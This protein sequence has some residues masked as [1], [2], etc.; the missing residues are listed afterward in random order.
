ML[1]N[2]NGITLIAMI[3]TIIVMLILAGISIA[4][5]AGENGVINK[6]TIAKAATRAGEIKEI[7]RLE[8]SNNKVAEFTNDEQKTRDKVIA[9]LV[10][11]GKLTPEEE[12]ELQN[13]ETPTITIGGITI[14]FSVLPESVQVWTQSGT[15]VTDGEITLTVGTKVSGYRVTGHEDLN[16]YVLGAKDGKLL[17]T[18]DTCPEKV[19]L[20]GTSG[21][22][23]ADGTYP[24][25]T[26]LN[27]VA[28]KYGDGDLADS[29]RTI[30]Y[31]DINRITGY[32][33]KTD[34]SA[35][36]E[37]WEYGNKVTYTLK[38]DGEVWYKGTKQPTEWTVSTITSF[39]YWDGTDWTP[40]EPGESTPN[41]VECTY[42]YCDVSSIDSGAKTLLFTNTGFYPG[43][44]SSYW[45][46][47][48]YIWCGACQAY[49]GL[50]CVYSSDIG[51]YDL[52]GSS[53]GSF[54]GGLGLRPVVSLRSSVKVTE[55]GV[56]SK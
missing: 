38:D 6:T 46:G 16:W 26:A 37:V 2:K 53:E 32:D 48:T 3:I 24:W 42:T 18:T 39:Q 17:I 34:G 27:T 35:V 15:S 25:V 23:N 7:V 40:L 54:S 36:G 28:A 12:Q 19:S 56:V 43:A 47:S 50:L 21:F 44:E 4:T 5:L 20:E 52:F 22:Q 13:A 55:A 9:E 10:A 31:D 51:Y 1:K 14:D 11:D 30:D 41:P 45:L 8:A 29:T 49:W 33:P